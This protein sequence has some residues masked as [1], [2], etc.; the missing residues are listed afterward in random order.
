MMVKKTIQIKKNSINLYLNFTY[1][2][3]N[4]KVCETDT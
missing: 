2:V 4:L 3:F 1:D